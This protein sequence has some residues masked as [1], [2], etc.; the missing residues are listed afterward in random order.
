MRYLRFLP[1]SCLVVLFAVACTTTTAPGVADEAHSGG[2]P[3]EQ[4]RRLYAYSCGRCHALYMPQSFFPDEWPYYVRRYGPKARLSK[5]QRDLVLR[6]LQ[7]AS[8]TP[9]SS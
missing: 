2:T 1:I 8:A 3:E 4:G 5:G 9:R 7:S 6:Y